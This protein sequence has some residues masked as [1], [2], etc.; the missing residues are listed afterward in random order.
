MNRAHPS[1]SKHKD[2][3]EGAEP[4]E[5]ALD[6]RPVA[7]KPKQPRKPKEPKEKKSSR[8]RSMTTMK[9]AEMEA[10]L[11]ELGYEATADSLPE[12]KEQLAY[13]RQKTEDQEAR[14]KVL[15]LLAVMAR[16]VAKPRTTGLI[17]S[18]RRSLWQERAERKAERER[19]K[20]IEKAER[21]KQREAERE[22]RRLQ[23][24]K[25]E[26]QR[27]IE[28]ERAKRYPMED[29]EVI[30]EEEEED[31]VKRA[32]GEVVEARPVIPTADMV[33]GEFGSSAILRDLVAITEFFS[34]FGAHYGFPT[35]GVK[36]R[37][38]VLARA[39]CDCGARR[40]SLD[41]MGAPAE[42]SLP[43]IY[44]GLARAIF[45]NLEAR[46]SEADLRNIY[47]EAPPRWGTCLNA[48][49]WPQ[50]VKRLILSSFYTELHHSC[51]ESAVLEAAKLLDGDGWK[52]MPASSH[53]QLMMGL[54]DDIMETAYVRQ[55]IDNNI[56][57]GMEVIKEKKEE[58]AEERRAKKEEE[59]EAKA[60]RKEVPHLSRLFVIASA[61]AQA[62]AARSR[63]EALN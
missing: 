4:T 62:E 48:N 21:A 16:E 18:C 33:D 7:P 40:S 41:L 17:G 44:E 29:M 1:P 36:V 14:D 15:T 54:V 47:P 34:T 8:W 20:A 22:Q 26:E 39:C 49:T 55:V 30:K 28:A 5:M 43:S 57:R 19:L 2:S 12:L 52:T 6:A 53:L 46:A 13:A 42:L 51:E 3:A 56:E 38:L 37:R 24:E 25:E 35:M 23:K 59:E 63:S 27:R 58:L 60:L 31:D 9:K 50:I 61:A 11:E 45:S 10:E 32:K